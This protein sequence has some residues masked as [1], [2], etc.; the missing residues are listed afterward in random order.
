MSMTTLE[1]RPHADF[2]PSAAH[3]A[4][5]PAGFVVFMAVSASKI[6]DEA[7]NA[8]EVRMSFTTP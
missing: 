2:A 3:A 4:G 5:A 7:K 6:A 8:I 1:G